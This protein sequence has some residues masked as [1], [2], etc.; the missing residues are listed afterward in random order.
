MLLTLDK[1]IFNGKGSEMNADS[2]STSFYPHTNTEYFFLISS[3]LILPPL[4]PLCPVLVTGAVEGSQSVKEAHG[5]L[6][7]T[8]LAKRVS[9]LGLQAFEWVCVHL[10]RVCS[11]K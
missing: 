8:V 1:Q 9:N 2:T 5:G 10:A 4:F 7:R 11:K 3:F 6:M